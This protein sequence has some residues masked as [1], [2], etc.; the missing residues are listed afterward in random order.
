MTAPVAT[1]PEHAEIYEALVAM[2][3]E[4]VQHLALEAQSGEILG[5]VH[6]SNLLQFPSYGPMVLSREV[7]RAGSA[8]QVIA[9]ALRAPSLAEALIDSGAPPERITRMLTAVCDAATV[10]FI[11]LAQEELGP[12]PAP[13][14][15][16]GLGSHGRQ[17]L[18]LTSDQDNALIY[19][20]EVAGDDDASEYFLAMG[21]RVCGWL[22]EAGFPYCRG[23][24]MAQNPRWSQPLQ[25][26]REYFSEWVRTAEPMEVL[27]FIAFFDFR[28]VHGER[29]LADA[30]RQHVFAEAAAHPSFFAQ[31]AQHVQRF[32]PPM[33]LFGRIVAG[34][35]AGQEGQMLNLKDAAAPLIG[36]ARVYAL[37]ERVAE[38][39]TLERL[40]GLAEAGGLADASRDETMAA[41]KNLMRLRLESQADALEAVREPDNLVAYRDLTDV[42]RTLV[43]QAFAQTAAV[44]KRISHD[45]LGDT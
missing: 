10:R 29:E 38:A 18:T 31:L 45:F 36:F 23:E 1:I 11:A 15:F 24:I 42:E 39:N 17:E 33:R 40:E 8:E 4:G 19:A 3:R 41:F 5:L 32:K 25:T 9:A 30:L 37:R 27:E 28:A 34:G 13:F 26:W 2:E 7:E 20:D 14:C 22:D 35:A 44:Q 43:N 12:P 6:H 16:L 21:R